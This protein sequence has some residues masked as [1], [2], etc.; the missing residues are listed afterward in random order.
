MK[1]MTN[2]KEF[3]QIHFGGKTF[4]DITTNFEMRQ[5]LNSYGFKATKE[6]ANEMFALRNNFVAQEV[7]A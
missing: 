2:P 4:M 1:T 3:C 5:F 6:L 7:T